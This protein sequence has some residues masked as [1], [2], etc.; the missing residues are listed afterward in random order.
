MA[1][2][3]LIC[4]NVRFSIKDGVLCGPL[5]NKQAVLNFKQGVADAVKQGGQVSIA[6]AVIIS[7]SCWTIAPLSFVASAVDW[8]QF[9]V[10]LRSLISCN[11]RLIS[12][13]LPLIPCNMRLI[14]CNVGL[15]HCLIVSCLVQIVIGGKALDRPGNFVQPTLVSIKPD[16]PVRKN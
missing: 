2:S 1:F 14:S 12:C 16:A 15:M 13:N 7:R 10:E 5:H 11:L 9:R 6:S 8:N 3:V 4:N